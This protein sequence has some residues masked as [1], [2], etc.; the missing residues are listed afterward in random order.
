MDTSPWGK[1]NIRPKAIG[2]VDPAKKKRHVILDS[3]VFITGL[4]IA[5]YFTSDTKYYVIKGVVDELR[6]VQARAFYANFPHKIT[7]RIPS[8]TP[9]HQIYT[10]KK[11]KVKQWIQR[12][13]EYRQLSVTD[14]DVIALALDIEEEMHGEENV[15]KLPT[16]QLCKLKTLAQLALENKVKYAGAQP[17]K[18]KGEEDA[19]DDKLSDHYKLDESLI[20]TRR[21]K[22][23][24]PLQDTGFRVAKTKTIIPFVLDDFLLL[25]QEQCYY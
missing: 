11:K 1:G 3:G 12:V 10:Q 6:D 21:D 22:I 24:E 18:E 7:E 20:M 8:I 25:V 14:R 19:G 16:K 23:T 2:S 17:N 9:N 4:N 15:N 5:N 13:P